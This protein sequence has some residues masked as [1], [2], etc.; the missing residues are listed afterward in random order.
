MIE[1]AL[2]TGGSGFIGTNLVEHAQAHGAAVCNLDVKPPQNPAQRDVWREADLLDAAAVARIVAEFAP[3]HVF[4][5]GART[6]LEG[7]DVPAYAA[8]TDGVRNVIDACRPVESI[9]RVLFASSRL[10]CKIGYQPKSD[11]DYAATTPYGQSKVVG[12]Q[13][14]RAE[15]D[16]AP[17]VMVRPTS[18]W[19]PWFDVPYKNFF[20]A[21]DAGR[22]VHPRGRRIEKSFGFVLNSVHELWTLMSA[23]EENVHGRTMYMCDYPPLEVRAWADLIQRELGGRPVREVPLPVLRAGALAGDAAKRLG[24]REPPLT[25]FR[26]DNLLT[27]MRYDT[28]PMEQIVGPLPHSVE[29]GVKRTVAWMRR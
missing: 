4:H 21:I 16:S 10:V 23:P 25:S 17:W 8:N 22:Y 24:W 9:R 15:M 27:N 12:E 18:I 29:E 5:L 2:I 14:V 26:L 11:T 19:G 6:D 13:I 1:R 3:T 20:E 7:R 28:A